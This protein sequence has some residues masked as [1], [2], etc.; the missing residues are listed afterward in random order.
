MILGDAIWDVMR[1]GEEAVVGNLGVVTGQEALD[2]VDCFG[3]EAKAG[4]SLGEYVMVNE[5]EE[6]R[7]VEHEGCGFQASVPGVVE[8]Q[9]RVEWERPP[10]WVPGT[11]LWLATSNWIGGD[12]FKN[13]A[14]A[15]HELY[16]S[17]R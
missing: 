16:G 3:V 15:F 13:F 12:F 11:M 7:D 14:G 9:A 4:K 1:V 2:K 5:V 6:A 8:R 10:N 17:E